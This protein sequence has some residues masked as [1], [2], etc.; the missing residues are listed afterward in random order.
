MGIPCR[1]SGRL[2]KLILPGFIDALKLIEESLD[3]EPVVEDGVES[4]L[5]D[6]WL[7]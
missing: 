5:G 1:A 3:G 2:A 4:E 6:G 7:G